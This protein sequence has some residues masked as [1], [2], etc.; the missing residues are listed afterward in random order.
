MPNEST[1]VLVVDDDVSVGKVLK[2]LLEQA[3]LE[4]VHELSA[5]AALRTLRSCAVDLVVTDLKMPGM[6]GMDLLRLVV[7]EW[8]DIPVI[9]LTAHGTVSIAVEAMKAGAAD[10]MLKPFDRDAVLYTVNKALKATER[11]RHQPPRRARLPSGFIGVSEAMQE[12]G[13]L[14]QR[15]GKSKA[16]VLIRGE[17]GTGKEL[18][19]QAIHDE[20]P[21]REGPFVIVHCAALP[22]NLL[23]S[24]LFG[25]EKGA[26]TGA[27]A[28]KPG[29]AELAEGGT[30]F[31]DEIGDLSLAVQVKL[32]RLVQDGEFQRLGATRS[33]KADLRFVAAT[34]RD[35]EAM[36]TA[37]EF[38]QDLFYRL[39]VLPI[40]L[41]PL[42]DRSQDIAALAEHFLAILVEQNQRPTMKLDGAAMDLLGRQSW[43][44]N[45]RQLQNFVE[46]L[47]VLSDGPA[48]GAADVERELFRQPGLC[49]AAS[50]APP[51]PPEQQ[52]A[53]SLKLSRHHAEREAVKTALER[54]GN[55]RTVAARLL[56]VS[57]RTLYNKLEEFGL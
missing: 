32:L 12:V 36:V 51:A 22:E 18:A 13:D 8:P 19:A 49:P 17:S 46:R 29:R 43:P 7:R 21:R 9:M 40:W 35:L 11:L 25:Y 34:H 37:G 39:N 27:V 1:T 15:A 42:R 23:E 3:G 33:Q 50:A 14:I 10:F 24:E 4:A 53:K 28:A 55:N 20:S 26:F 41:P 16:T 44:G 6:D 30:L 5:E 56:G 57:R 45:V 38:R 48:I 2:A 31:L 54:A 47:V 52:D